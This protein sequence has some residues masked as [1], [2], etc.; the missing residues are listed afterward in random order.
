[1]TIEKS[2][3]K[4]VDVIELLRGIAALGVVCY[5]FANSTLPTIK[6]NPIGTFFEWAKLGIP[7]FF[8]ISGYVIPLSMYQSGYDIRDAGRFFIKRMVR[9]IPPAWMAIL[10]MVAIYYA[11]YALNGRPI[12]GMSWPGTS[13]KGIL[14]NLFFSFHL[15]DVDKYIDAY[16]TLEIEFQFYILITFLY[17]LILFLTR[18]PFLLTLLFIGLSCTHYLWGDKVLFFRDNSFFILGILLF[19]HKTNKISRDYFLYASFAATVACFMQQGV[20]GSA[21]AV[22]AILTMNFV[23]LNNP[24]TNFLGMI[25]FSL[26]ITHK[27]S[28]VVAEFFFRNI[29]GLTP[30]NPTK[31]LM[32]FIYVGC[33]ILF[34]Y[35]FYKL[36]EAPSMK[37]SKK[38]RV[39]KKTV[40]TID[41]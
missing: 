9:M 25:S 19:L 13:L 10:L 34:A 30:D 31:V 28:G 5:H 17:P 38:I 2:K 23:I 11:G 39:H 18:K 12:E 41:K 1:M 7:M 40:T 26:Y 6:P 3:E 15:F 4:H 37:L 16:W 29:T 24:V 32:L 35:V 20:Y 22:M 33:S 27:A 36:V 8:I 14:A 21:G